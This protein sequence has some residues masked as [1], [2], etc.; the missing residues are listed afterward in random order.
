MGRST[1][2]VD[3]DDHRRVAALRPHVLDVP[4]QLRGAHEAAGVTIGPVLAVSLPQ[5][6]ISRV[7][8]IAECIS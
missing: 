7:A 1:S 6:P 4:A 3:E 2:A 5:S 8:R